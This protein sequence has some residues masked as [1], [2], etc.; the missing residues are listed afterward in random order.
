[1]PYSVTA[2]SDTVEV[3]SSVRPPFE[4]K[5]WLVDLRAD[6]KKAVAGLSDTGLPLYARYSSAVTGL[7]DV[8]N[9]LF[10]NLGKSTFSRLAKRGLVFER[11]F[12]LSS[13]PPSSDLEHH[14]LYSQR[15]TSSFWRQKFI[16]EWSITLSDTATPRP[17]FDVA[18]IWDRLKV[19]DGIY[20]SRVVA[21][22]YGLNLVI[23]APPAASLNLPAIVKS[24]FDGV[25]SS[26]HVY[27]GTKLD[28][29]SRRIGIHLGKEPGLIK[30]QLLDDRM[31]ILGPRDLVWPFGTLGVQWNP[32][33]D[34]CVKG[35]LSRQDSDTGWKLSGAFFE[36]QPIN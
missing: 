24:L 29:V 36:L 26:F 13:N 9:V 32:A 6:V 30:E 18:S 34:L 16:T 25:I 31:A 33:D 22:V 10:Y 21:S 11:A 35:E 20:P 27:S 4:P 23:H 14:L 8:E 15:P 3:W 19:V 7:C 12:S 1:M 5:G 28:E 17:R 2:N